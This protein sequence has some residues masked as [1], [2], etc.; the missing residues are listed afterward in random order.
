MTEAHGATPCASVISVYSVSY[1]LIAR[2]ATPC[3]ARLLNVLRFPDDVVFPVV[4]LEKSQ[5]LFLALQVIAQKGNAVGVDNLI[6]R[7][8]GREVKLFAAGAAFAVADAVTKL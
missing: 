7:L 6:G 2:R 5:I 8:H 3:L 4:L 1:S